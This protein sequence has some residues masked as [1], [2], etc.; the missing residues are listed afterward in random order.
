MPEGP[1]G[2]PRF[3][4]LGPL[5]ELPVDQDDLIIKTTERTP[6]FGPGWS[7]L[8]FLSDQGLLD[9]DPASQRVPT[10]NVKRVTL[11]T[12]TDVPFFIIERDDSILPEAK[13]GGTFALGKIQYTWR[14]KSILTSDDVL[15]GAT[16]G[17]SRKVDVN[18]Q[19][20]RI[21]VASELKSIMEDDLEE[22]GVDVVYVLTTTRNGFKLNKSLNYEIDDD[23]TEAYFESN[24]V[25]SRET[26]DTS[27]YLRW[28]KKQL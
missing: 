1:L 19:V 2:F 22:K 25:S 28:M 11:S 14:D 8:E 4:D 27:P 15:F 21:G 20:R 12:D 10:M 13:F 7:E 18:K 24:F 6:Q 16:I 17:Y 9:L 26:L 3:S 23:L 5:T